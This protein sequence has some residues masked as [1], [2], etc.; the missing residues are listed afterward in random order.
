MVDLFLQQDTSKLP[1]RAVYSESG[2]Y[3]AAS[4]DWLIDRTCV[5]K[6]IIAFLSFSTCLATRSI[7]CPSKSLR[8]TAA[9]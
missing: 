1:K 3:E 2:S 4:S 5:L 8:P 9:P 7:P 6:Y